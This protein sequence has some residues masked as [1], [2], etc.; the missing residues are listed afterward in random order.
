MATS[1]NATQWPKQYPHTESL[2]KKEIF[3]FPHSRNGINSF[4]SDT[5]NEI[6]AVT[7]EKQMTFSIYNLLRYINQ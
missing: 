6:E 5:V 7:R 1:P 3:C 4:D 2:P